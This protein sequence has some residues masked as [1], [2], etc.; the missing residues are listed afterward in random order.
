MTSK[1]KSELCML[2][3]GGVFFFSFFF[4][5]FFFHL[6]SACNSR[7]CAT[8]LS[9]LATRNDPHS[10]MLG[11]NMFLRATA[12]EFQCLSLGS[13]IAI[14]FV[15]PKCSPILGRQARLGY[16]ES[17]YGSPVTLQKVLYITIR[18]L[19]PPEIDAGQPW[20]RDFAD[21]A[22]DICIIAR[23]MLGDRKL[24]EAT[25]SLHPR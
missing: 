9:S 25:Q 15:R 14:I 24:L 22:K 23:A 3:M 16:L 6:P 21:D 5:D 8:P 7:K 12:L 20:P 1:S 4:L 2:S 18:D 17:A 11:V 13:P 10:P 19:N